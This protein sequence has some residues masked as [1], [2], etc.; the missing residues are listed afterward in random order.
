MKVWE[1]WKTKALEAEAVR[2]SALEQLNLQKER[3]DYLATVNRDQEKEIETL[4]EILDDVF[5]KYRKL[6]GKL[7]HIMRVM[8]EN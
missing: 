3:A 4:R 5:P 7:N 8:D 2:D 6:Q 1:Q